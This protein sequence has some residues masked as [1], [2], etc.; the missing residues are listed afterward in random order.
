[1]G[2]SLPPHTLKIHKYFAKNPHPFPHLHLNSK[3]SIPKISQYSMHNASRYK[4][5]TCNP[6]KCLMCRSSFECADLARDPSFSDSAPFAGNR[7][8]RV[9]GPLASTPTDSFPGIGGGEWQDV[10]RC[11]YTFYKG[12][13]KGWEWGKWGNHT[14]YYIVDILKHQ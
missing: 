14:L 1:M 6:P 9:A 4:H 10:C 12:G 11:F 5:N 3:H 8:F 2:N 13:E 7:V